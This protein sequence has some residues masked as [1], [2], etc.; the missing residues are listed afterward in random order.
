MIYLL[1][2]ALLGN[3]GASKQYD[4]C[5]LIEL[6]TYYSEEGNLAYR[7]YIFYDWSPDS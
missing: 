2:F 4:T 6:N 1:V 5:D 7:Q 3:A